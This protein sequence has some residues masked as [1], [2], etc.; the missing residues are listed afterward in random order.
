MKMKLYFFCILTCAAFLPS[1]TKAQTITTY[2][3]TGVPGFGGDGA[4]ATAAQLYAPAG[5]ALD[6]NGNIYIADEYNHRVRK[7]DA[8]GNITTIAGTGVADARSMAEAI[9]VAGKICAGTWLRCW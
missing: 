1:I 5:I 6:A 8:T 9:R 4:A 7:V 2:A 3:G